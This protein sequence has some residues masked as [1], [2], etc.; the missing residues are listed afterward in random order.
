MRFVADF[1]CVRATLQGTFARKI[2]ILM[3]QL[4]VPRCSETRPV[5]HLQKHPERRAAAGMSLATAGASRPQ[6]KEAL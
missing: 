6:S 1:G 4:D 5:I 2:P 3:D